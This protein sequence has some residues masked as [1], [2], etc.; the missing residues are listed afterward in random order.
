MKSCD[1]LFH[2]IIVTIISIIIFAP[3]YWIPGGK[4]LK[5]KQVSGVY[6][7]VKVLWKETT[8]THI[9]IISI[10]FISILVLLS[11]FVLLLLI[12]C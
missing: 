12:D 6:S 1:P 10:I 4:I 8:F 9:M 2:L 3:Q 7:V 11:V 5:T